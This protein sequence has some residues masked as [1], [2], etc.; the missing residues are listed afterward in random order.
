[1]EKRELEVLEKYAPSDPDLKDLWDDHRL[2][3]KQVDKLKAKPYR[4]PT[5]EMTL[6]Q[7]K[8]QKLESKT[9]LMAKVAIYLE[10]EK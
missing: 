2:Y 4:T 10:Q 7:L 9:K 8:K 6:A 1:M 3:S 5:E